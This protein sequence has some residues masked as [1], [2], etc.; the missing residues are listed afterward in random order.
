M[1]LRQEDGGV[2]AITQPAHAWLSG[3]MANAWG[4][5]LFAGPQPRQD[6]CL[7]A[8]LHDIGWL[9]WEESPDFDPGTGW[10]RVFADVPAEQHTQ[11]WTRGVRRVATLSRYAATLVSMHGDTIYDKTF[12]PAAARPEAAEAVRLF[13]AEGAAFQRAAMNGLR[14]D[15]AYAAFASEWQLAANKR[16]IGAVDT[17]SLQICWG[18]ARAEVAD[19]PLAE[20]RVTTLVLNR[21][22]DRVRLDPWPF[23]RSALTL[24]IPGR[25]L[26]GP[27]RSK[28][29][30]DAALAGAETSTLEITLSPG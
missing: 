7:A 10:P 13:R 19:V 27:F 28:S 3:V 6:V 18:T 16:L 17:L 20:D 8:S 11:L 23:D 25:R 1:L 12:D 24:N 15:P 22:G 30:M 4:N 26:P 9:D 5:A 14:Q 2:L 21:D 29:D